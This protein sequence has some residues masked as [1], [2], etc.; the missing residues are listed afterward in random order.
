MINLKIFCHSMFLI[1][2]N[3]ILFIALKSD[4]MYVKG[5]FVVWGIGKTIGTIGIF[6]VLFYTYMETFYI[7]KYKDNIAYV[8]IIT[9]YLKSPLFFIWIIMNFYLFLVPKLLI[10][11]YYFIAILLYIFQCILLL[12]YQKQLF[13]SFD[14]FNK[15]YKM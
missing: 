15:N 4:R 1:I 10:M 9:R 2:L 11:N 13:Q 6:A 14:E 3:W 8:N 12:Y 5:Y 7:N